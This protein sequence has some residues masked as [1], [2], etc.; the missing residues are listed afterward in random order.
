MGGVGAADGLGPGF[1][2]PEVADLALL[3]QA[4]HRAHRLLDR[5]RVVDAVL[6]VEIDDV[7]FEP[8]EA[9]LARLPHIFGR[10][11]DL[12]AL[13]R[14]D[15]AELGGDD[16]VVAPPLDRLG[17]QFL[18]LA[19]GIGVRGIE[20]VDADIERTLDGGDGAR[21]VVLAVADRHAHAAEPDGRD[22]QALRAQF[23]V[24]H[25]TLPASN[26]QPPL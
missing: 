15:L 9:R 19:V 11:V 17:D 5:H 3:D 4:R 26:A 2:E 22:L 24:F 21:I 12:E 8:L 16:G 6:V 1:G 18:V 7:D 23:A 13:G 20:Q 10:T 14:A 25:C